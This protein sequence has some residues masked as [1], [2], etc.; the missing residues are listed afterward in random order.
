MDERLERLSALAARQHGVFS[1]RQAAELGLDRDAVRNGVRRSRWTPESG[2]VFRMAGVERRPSTRAMAAV[3]DCGRG[4]ALSHTSAA[5]LH[6]LPGFVVDPVHV[7][8]P[9]RPRSQLA[10]VHHSTSLHVGEVAGIPVTSVARTLLDLGAVVRP[11]RVERAVDTALARLLT[12]YEELTGV[13]NGLAASGRPGVRGLRA[14]LA[15]RSPTEAPPVSELERRFR[16][17]LRRYGLPQPERQVVLGAD[18]EVAGRV[19]CYFRQAR[20]V[21]ELDGRAYH[22]AVLDR[23]EDA[24]RDLVLL[25]SGR[26]VLRLGWQHVVDRPL[27][28]LQVLQELLSCAA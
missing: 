2:R 27:E 5:C 14:A 6:R 24:R 26:R 9:S 15:G 7:T 8:C 23:L 1:R 16:D 10:V 18:G 19:D 21:V 20:L 3:L 17:L 12:T 11:G 28:V 25:R 22:S 4:A 13:L